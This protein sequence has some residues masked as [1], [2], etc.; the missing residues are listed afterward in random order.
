MCGEK[1][2]L[3]VLLVSLFSL[4]LFSQES[5]RL[6]FQISPSLWN[7]IDLNLQLLETQTED[8][9]KL[10][11][12]QYGQILKLENAYL[13]TYQLYLNSENNLKQLNQ[14][15]KKCKESLKIWRIVGISATGV[16]ILTIIGVIIYERVH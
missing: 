3:M 16:T 11:E 10:T 1:R 6:G 4:P 14:D 15:M 9:Q 5:N 8:M 13:D 7:S 2:F 12:K